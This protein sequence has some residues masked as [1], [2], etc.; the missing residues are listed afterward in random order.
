MALG[1]GGRKHSRA[2]DF[3]SADDA[4]ESC[5]RAAASAPPFPAP[6]AL[7]SPQPTISPRR[8][9]PTTPQDCVSHARCQR[10]PIA[11]R[12]APELPFAALGIRGPPARTAPVG[13]STRL[14]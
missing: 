11:T 7:G 8:A 1:C 5:A 4:P 13:A 6:A 14:L 3:S 12:H 9:R 2:V 10:A